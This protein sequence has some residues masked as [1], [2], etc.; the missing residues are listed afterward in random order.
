MEDSGK[1]I[2]EREVI[3]WLL[4]SGDEP[5]YSYRHPAPRSQAGEL[6]SALM[7]KNEHT[8][9]RLIKSTSIDAHY[10]R[11]ALNERRHF[12]VVI[13]LINCHKFDP[14]YR[15]SGGNNLL[16]IAC[17]LFVKEF[18]G[19]QH[20]VSLR[21]KEII[22]YAIEKCHCDP[23]I[24]NCKGA[25]PLHIACC[26]KLVPLEVTQL[27][28]KCDV[29]TGLSSSWNFDWSM[30]LVPGDTP[31]HIACLRNSIEIV[32]YLTEKCHCDPQ[33]KNRKGALALHIACTVGSLSIVRLVSNCDV[34]T[35]L[36]SEWDFN[37]SMKLVPGDTPL[38]IACLRNSIEI[39]KYLTEECHCD[40]QVQNFQGVLPLHIACSNGPLEMVKLV[41]HWNT[42]TRIT[43]TCTLM[44][45]R[46]EPKVTVVKG[47]TPLHIACRYEADVIVRYLIEECDCDPQIKNSEGVLALH[48]ACAVGSLSIVRLVSNCGVNTGLASSSTWI[49]RH[50]KELNVTEGDTP[51]HIACITKVDVIVKYLIEECHCDSQIQ[52]CEGALALHIACAVRSL[53]IVRLVSNCDVN[54]GLSSEWDFSWSMK[55]VPG[56]TPLHIACLRNSIE[57]V[58]YLTE[59]CHCDPQVQNCQGVLPL[60]IACSNGP[61]EMVKLVSHCNTNTR[62]TSTCTLMR[63]RNE[64]KVTVVKGDTPL[65]IACRYEA[66]V[67]VRYLIEECDCDPQI[68]NSEGVLALHIACAVGSLS[69]VRLVSN[70]GVNTGLAS[71]STWILR[72]GK[73][74][75][76]TEGDTPLHIACI[77]KVD[78]IVKYLIEECHCDSQIQNCEGAL[79]LHI[80]CAVRSLSIVRLVSNCD[81]NTGL[82]SEWD[83]E[84]FNTSMKIVPG[85]TPLH[86]ACLLSSIELVKYLT[87]E[88]HCDFRIRNYKGMLPL[89]YVVYSHVLRY[90]A[91][92]YSDN[93][94]EDGNTILHIA[95]RPCVDVSQSVLVVKC[96]IEGKYC[97]PCV[98]NN[99][100]ELPLHVACSQK[101]LEIV[102]LVSN[103]DV[104]GKTRTTGDTPLHIACQNGTVE[105]VKYL[106]EH[107]R[108]DPAA[109]NNSKETCLETA[110]MYGQL[111]VVKYL[112]NVAIMNIPN[113]NGELTIHIACRQ[114]SLDFVELVSNYT[115]D[116]N[117]TAQKSGD[118]PLHIACSNQTMRFVKYLTEIK[119]CNPN[120]PNNNGE[121]PLHIACREQATQIA[122]MV[123]GCDINFQ[124]KLGNTPLHEACGASKTFSFPNKSLEVIRHLVSHKKC[125]VNVR[126]KEGKTA[127]HYACKAQSVELVNYLLLNGKT[128]LSITDNKRQT[129][130]MF[131]TNPALI[132][133]LLH[134][135]ADPRPLYKSFAQYFR[136][137]S[138]ENPPPTPQK[139]LVVGNAGAGKTSLIQS[140]ESEGGQNKG[141]NEPQPTAGIIPT[142]FQ[143][144]IYGPVIW[145]DF[146]GQKEYYASHEA[147]LH[148][149]IAFSSPVILLVIDISK[150]EANIRQHLLYWL[151]FISKCI[152]ARDKPHLIVIGSH[153]DIVMKESIDPNLKL[154]Q[155]LKNVTKRFESL[156]IKLVGRI[157]M[158]CRESRSSGITELQERLKSSSSQLRTD[159]VVGF[160][161]HCFYIFLLNRFKSKPAI[162]VQEIIDAVDEAATEE[163]ADELDDVFSLTDSESASSLS[164]EDNESSSDTDYHENDVM[165]LLPDKSETIQFCEDLNDRGHIILVQDPHQYEHS[166]VILNKEE[167]LT[168]VNGTVFAPMDFPEHQIL[169]SS[170][171]VVPLSK[172]VIHFPK[173]NPNMLVE[174]LSQ[175]EFCH[176]IKDRD[177]LKLIYR[178]NTTQCEDLERYFFFPSLVSITRP[179]GVW[180]PNELFNY[181]CGFILHCSET[182]KFFT[183]RF[184]PVLIL[185]LAFLFALVPCTHSVSPAI[186]R[187]CCVWKNGISWINENGIESVVEVLED[188]QTV[189]VMLRCVSGEENEAQCIFHRSSVIHT[190]LSTKADI[191][192]HISTTEFFI[193]P[194]CVQY[195]LKVCDGVTLFSL[196]AIARAVTNLKPFIVSD[197]GK[198]RGFVFIKVEELLCFEPFSDCGKKVLQ[199]MFEDDNCSKEVSDDFILSM[200]DSIAHQAKS[201]QKI[202]WLMK[203][204]Q[205]PL[206][207][208]QEQTSQVPKGPT[209]E[210]IGLFQTWRQCTAGT[211]QCL[212]ETLDKFSVFCGRN[213]LVS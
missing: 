133:V 43:S 190:I 100:W 162:T 175:L 119:Q 96:L 131:A 163:D 208:L 125:K 95:C 117:A 90:I 115:D 129:P 101:A 5:L 113:D 157:P 7:R 1:F 164:S 185:R 121:L 20:E 102:K 16:H 123:S 154:Q 174:F 139:I 93:Q 176:E 156:R 83:F 144:D 8:V 66:D 169:S 182:D 122:I 13:H 168:S 98:Q 160:I 81:V 80:A 27:L 179:E 67:I 184:L 44:R 199:E 29:N 148:N 207:Q 180:R 196:A 143:S 85:D 10:L 47:D 178:D 51:L 142:N 6:F 30:K 70:C 28:S 150:N 38:H 73:E 41:S 153:A 3:R 40:P 53:S 177:V 187:L 181:K 97:S 166:W 204:F 158:D 172:L 209:R 128:D 49:L 195:P 58:K 94:D 205:L 22:E 155:V 23:Q 114:N 69:I 61:L 211:Y 120:I 24:K 197:C 124:T 107:H 183:P 77:T 106:I 137:H 108:C 112:I 15:D 212:R 92:H 130:V 109:L 99:E 146:A 26:G 193:H 84:K 57:I 127:I 52:N 111:D 140:L 136:D 68:K 203:V 167:I 60:H 11:E 186:E 46:N 173:F 134:Y 4:F 34:N 91:S 75:N 161:C 165:K 132:K 86:I 89:H 72:H 76:V 65:H 206:S 126:N 82:S 17:I 191:C 31:L 149:L 55:H 104:G 19:I 39:V 74:L 198:S 2:I 35:G 78:M 171:G 135:G 12:D 54:T 21:L 159:T 170:T 56:D 210:L 103:C 105:V 138:S 32:K 59:E 145:Y 14:Q 192:P 37:W 147:I 88:C 79:A 36:S 45:D 188:I 189:A 213:P 118:T 141:S 62:I 48:I 202:K 9:V 42:N 200:A 152:S 25:L 110:V 18:N 194:S 71:S 33:I 87:E 116:I 151:A 63:D 201:T 50:G 64:P